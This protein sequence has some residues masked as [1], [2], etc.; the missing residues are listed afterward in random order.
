VANWDWSLGARREEKK[1][2]NFVNIITT[3]RKIKNVFYLFTLNEIKPVIPEF[4]ATQPHIET[5]IK[6]PKT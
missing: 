6:Y 3:W 4:T 1:F 2:W 5:Y